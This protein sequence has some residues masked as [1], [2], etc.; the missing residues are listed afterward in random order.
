MME[1]LFLSP[2]LE[3]SSLALPAEPA[4]RSAGNVGPKERS[5][6]VQQQVR[7]TMARR[8]RRSAA[9]GKVCVSDGPPLVPSLLEPHISKCVEISCNI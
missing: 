6:R 2:A 1:E 7:Q 3:D 4:R 9:N 8:A 5:V